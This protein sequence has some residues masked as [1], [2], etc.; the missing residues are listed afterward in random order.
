MAISYQIRPLHSPRELHMRF[1][2]FSSFMASRLA[3]PF[4]SLSR[5]FFFAFWVALKTYLKN[6]SGMCFCYFHCFPLFFS[7]SPSFKK[8]IPPTLRILFF[9][10]NRPLLT[11]KLGSLL[12][13]KH[14]PNEFTSVPPFFP[15]FFIP[16]IFVPKTHPNAQSSPP[17][18]AK[19]QNHHLGCFGHL[20]WHHGTPMM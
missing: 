16:R 4:R 8:N 7:G 14:I 9:N 19:F 5:Q 2:N 10:V 15:Y 20:P 18:N 1:S 11:A 12:L 3:N 17:M 13:K 6:R